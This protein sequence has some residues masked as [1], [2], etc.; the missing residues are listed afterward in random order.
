LDDR[1]KRRYHATFAEFAAANE[2]NYNFLK[3]EHSINMMAEIPL[4]ENDYPSFYK[5]DR[6]GIPRVFG[7]NKVLG[8]IQLLSTK[9]QE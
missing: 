9:L 3:D 2:L 4:V 5:P 8:I 1:K 7:G 6:I